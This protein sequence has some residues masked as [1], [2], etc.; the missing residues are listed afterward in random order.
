M[1]VPIIANMNNFVDPATI[2]FI[3]KYRFSKLIFFTYTDKI[4]KVKTSKRNYTRI[5]LMRR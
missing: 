4:V 3:A 2:A 5:N 1:I